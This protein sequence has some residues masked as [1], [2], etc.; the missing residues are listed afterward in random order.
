MDKKEGFVCIYGLQYLVN[1]FWFN[2][3]LFLVEILFSI[4]IV[5]KLPQRYFSSE[6]LTKFT[7]VEHTII[8][9]AQ[10]LDLYRLSTYITM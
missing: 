9:C 6:K 5:C 1:W 4:F 8:I 3:T 2:C 7:K 10:V